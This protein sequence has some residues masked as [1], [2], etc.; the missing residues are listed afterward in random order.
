MMT[1]KIKFSK[2][3]DPMTMM[4]QKYILANIMFEPSD[5]MYM[6]SDQPSLLIV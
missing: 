2:K 5:I 1:A 3:N 6:R 4:Q